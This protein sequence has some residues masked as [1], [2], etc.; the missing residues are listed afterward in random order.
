MANGSEACLAKSRHTVSALA[1]RYEGL[2][3]VELSAATYWG[4]IRIAW[5][6]LGL[7]LDLVE[8]WKHEQAVGRRT[9]LSP[10]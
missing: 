4:S 3:S 5:V 9:T 8:E 1:Y 2:G 7:G 10:C 6:R